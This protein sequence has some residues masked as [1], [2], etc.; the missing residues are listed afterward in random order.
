MLEDEEQ[1]GYVIEVVEDAKA[2]LDMKVHKYVQVHVH[3]TCTSA[4]A[5]ISVM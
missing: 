1:K 2:M 5:L 3:C 4:H